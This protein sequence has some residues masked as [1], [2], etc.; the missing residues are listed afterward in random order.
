MDTSAKVRLLLQKLFGL[1]P[2][3]SFTILK[4]FIRS[5]WCLISPGRALDHGFVH[6]TCIPAM[7]VA[8][9]C[10]FLGLM[11]SF[12]KKQEQACTCFPEVLL[13]MRVRTPQVKGRTKPTSILAACFCPCVLHLQPNLRKLNQT[14]GISLSIQTRELHSQW[15]AGGH[16][17]LRG[18]R[19]FGI[20]IMFGP[21]PGA[22]PAF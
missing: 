8:H 7:R 16:V 12:L 6:L 3:M 22:V 11:V 5:Y 20:K 9:C 21:Q 14:R 10:S 15:T 2:D 1:R 18:H 13:C 19:C 17:I 4:I